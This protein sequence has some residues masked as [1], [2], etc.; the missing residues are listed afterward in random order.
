MNDLETRAEQAFRDALSR[1]ADAFEPATLAPIRRQ[2]HARRIGLIA[3]AASV[4]LVLGTTV[5]VALWR[6]SSD[7]GPAED[8]AGPAAGWRYESYRD[9]QIE[10]PESWGY[11]AAPGSDWCA[12]LAGGEGRFP[13]QPYV[14]TSGRFSLLLG[15][16]CVGRA[17]LLGGQVPER[18]WES[19]VSLVAAGQP[20]AVEDGTVTAKGWTRIA[21]TIGSVQLRV[22][23]DGE[24]LEQARR[25]AASAEVVEADHNGCPATSD[26]QAERYV[27]PTEAF[28]VTE[29][30][31]VDSISVCQYAIGEGTARPWLLASRKLTGDPADD[32]LAAVKAAP[33]GGGPNTPNSCLHGVNK[34]PAIV[35]RLNTADRSHEIYVYNAS[36]INN[37]FDDGTTVRALTREACVPL[38]GGR[39]T[40]PLGSGAPAG[41]CVPGATAEPKP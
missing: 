2:P 3:V 35:L 22:L 4:L 8:T 30:A 25:I 20:G 19:H 5:G 21:R 6:G 37:G 38:Y 34:E 24:H 31:D 27:R 10:V 13:T 9:V 36:C 17:D 26:I 1:Q 12:D 28:D 7:R 40:Y 39:V 15:I 11:A 23:A 41:R 18:L 16:G 33:A 14:D 32:V 29:V